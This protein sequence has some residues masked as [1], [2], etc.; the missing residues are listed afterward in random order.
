[1]SGTS[2][3]VPAKRRG[4]MRRSVIP[5]AATTVAVLAALEVA[6]QVIADG[7]TDPNVRLYALAL[8]AASGVLVGLLRKAG[9]ML[10]PLA[11]A[12][13]SGPAEAGDAARQYNVT[14][15]TSACPTGTPGLLYDLKEPGLTLNGLKAWNLTVC[16]SSGQTFTGVGGWKACVFRRSPGPNKWALAPLFYQDMED[17][18]RGNALT[19]TADNPCLTFWD[20]QVGVNDGDLLYV[21]PTPNLGVSGGTAVSVYLEGVF[22]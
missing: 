4:I 18:G 9:L 8:S 13:A 22:G 16:P 7:H 1:M 21:Y 5:G 20:L 12:V 2:I 15:S 3:P 17:D 6:L 10:V 19:S 14:I 11:L